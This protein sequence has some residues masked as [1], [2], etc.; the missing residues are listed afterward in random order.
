MFLPKCHFPL[1]LGRSL[2]R[3]DRKSWIWIEHS[4]CHPTYEITGPSPTYSNSS[5]RVERRKTFYCTWWGDEIKFWPQ[6]TRL[7]TWRS[8]CFHVSALT[9]SCCVFWCFSTSNISNVLSVYLRHLSPKKRKNE[10]GKARSCETEKL[11]NQW[12]RTSWIVYIL[13][14]QFLTR[15]IS[16]V[17]LLKSKSVSFLSTQYNWQRFVIGPR[18]FWFRLNVCTGVLL[19]RVS[20]CTFVRISKG[21]KKRGDYGRTCFKLATC[22]RT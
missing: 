9:L 10:R 3:M 21:R 14:F 19:L 7:Q 11:L 8:A 1:G 17:W 16:I 13:T 2:K 6:L 20:Y 18:K 12:A 5:K 4:Q 22:Q 15:Y